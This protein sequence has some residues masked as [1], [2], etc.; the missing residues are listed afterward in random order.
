MNEI[1]DDLKYYLF[2]KGYSPFVKDQI[3]KA[4]DDLYLDCAISTTEYAYMRDSL[5]KELY[6]A[7]RGARR[8]QAI[9][10]PKDEKQKYCD[11]STRGMSMRNYQR[12]YREKKAQEQGKGTLKCYNTTAPEFIRFDI[13]IQRKKRTV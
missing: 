12:L 10:L 7:E 1:L 8:T 4:L 6:K 2:R 5:L 9:D 11:Q 13:V 3:L